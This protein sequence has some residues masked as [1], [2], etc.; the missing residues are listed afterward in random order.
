MQTSTGKTKQTNSGASARQKIVGT[1]IQ[2][3][4]KSQLESCRVR[5]PWSA[6]AGSRLAGHVEPEDRA[7]IAARQDLSGITLPGDGEGLHHVRAGAGD[8]LVH[9]DDHL[10]HQRAVLLSKIL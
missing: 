5:L 4:A 7:Q 3:R 2:L 9:V 10:A 1:S 6:E 8:E